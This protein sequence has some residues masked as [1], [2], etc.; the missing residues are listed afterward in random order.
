MIL[1][2]WDVTEASSIGL[3]F[4]GK[5]F[6]LAAYFNF[7]TRL[8]PSHLTNTEKRQHYIDLRAPIPET[9][10]YHMLILSL[11]SISSK[12]IALIDFNR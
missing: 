8:G 5:I 1:E 3:W 2:A 11:Q 6:S 4:A 9:P 12:S 7:G 10:S